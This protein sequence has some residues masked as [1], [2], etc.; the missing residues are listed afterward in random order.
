MV[1]MVA[2]LPHRLTICILTNQ[3]SYNCLHMISVFLLRETTLII[4]KQF[5]MNHHLSNHKVTISSTITWFYFDIALCQCFSNLNSCNTIC[6][7]Y[8]QNV[9]NMFRH[10]IYDTVFCIVVRSSAHEV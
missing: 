3:H 9:Y 2:T 7:L 10:F 1:N 5:V 4:C 8:T 6:I